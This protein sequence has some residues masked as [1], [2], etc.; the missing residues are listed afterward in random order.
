[1]SAYLVDTSVWI[2]FFNPKNNSPRKQELE[3]LINRN[4]KI[5][6]CPVIYQE[7]LQGIRDDR[8]FRKTKYFISALNM[9]KTNQMTAIDHAVN[10]YRILRKNGVTIRK[11]QDC[12]IA[13]Y[14][15]I[16]NLT[17]LHNDRDFDSISTMFALSS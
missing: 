3:T 8:D 4:A 6:I 14:A 1:M 12:L 9:V 13:S 11:P 2:D 16:E 7:I 10:M 17:L 15:I 5:F